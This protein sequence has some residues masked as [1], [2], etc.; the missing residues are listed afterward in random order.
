MSRITGW[1]YTLRSFVRRNAADRDMADEIAF[2]IDCQ[3]RKHAAAGSSI[4]TA[5][6]R[7]LREFG[8]IVRWREEARRA[9]GSGALDV[10]EQDLRATLRGLRRSPAFATMA[11][12]TLALAIG[13]S[14]TVFT[15]INGVLLRPLPFASADRLMTVSYWPAYVKGWLG[16]PAMM[17]RDFVTFQRANR[18]FD[19]VALIIP[20]GAQL[21]RTGEAETL[22]GAWVTPDFFAVLGVKP[23]LGR[24]FSSNDGSTTGSGVVV[25]SNT[26]WRERFGADSSIVGRTIMLDGQLQTVIGV[27]PPGFDF[28]KLPAE[29]PVRGVTPFPPSEY[30]LAIAADPMAMNYPGPVIGRLRPGVTLQQAQVELTTMAKGSFVAFAQ[31]QDWCC[32]L[33][34]RL[35]RSATPQV[36]PLRDLYLAPPSL[37]REESRDARTPLLFFAAAVALVLAIA[38]S[39]VAG[40]ILMRTMSRTHEIAIRA[41]IGATRWRLMRLVLTE[42]LCISVA[43]AAL[44]VP[45]AAAGVRVVLSL[46]PSGA[47]PLANQVSVDSRVLALSVAMVLVCGLFAGLA[48]AIVASHQSPQRTLG[49]GGRM[50]QRHP[51]LETTTAA[52]VAFALMLL[53]GAGL[54]LQSFLR[55]QAVRL[56]FE[57]AGVVVM[58][59]APHGD[60]WWSPV[61]M[62]RLRD[63]VVSG[64]SGLRQVSSVGVESR[65]LVGASPGF[66][67]PLTVE[68]R[69]DTLPG[70][71]VSLVSP[72]Y[73]RT[74]GVPLIAGRTFTAADDEGAPA[75]AIVSHSLAAKAWPGQSALGKR[76]WVDVLDSLPHQLPKPGEWVTV[77]GVVGDAVQGSVRRAAPGMVYFPIDQVTGILAMPIWEFSVRAAGDPAATMRAMRR[78]MHDVAPGVPIEV[79]APLASLVATERAQPLFQTRLVTTFSVLALLL[80]AVGTYSTL[81]YAVVQ[82]RHELAIRL[83]L[84]AQPAN[85][86]RL[87]ASRG[88]GLA[89]A[90]V[91]VGLVGSFALTRALQSMLYHT[92]AT[93]PRVFAAAAVVLLVVAILACIVPTHRATRVD[94]ID[95]LREI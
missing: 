78:V 43:G 63:Q 21:T 9:R 75:V 45:L 56:G 71:V 52:S 89:L 61:A 76:V 15:V 18:S 31:H 24:T 91:C 48:P 55:L 51:V 13:A 17:G 23:A 82:R 12:V 79:L 68:G 39:N 25:I 95:A 67:G 14:T 42:S 59:L 81:A 73:F 36:R 34:H 29:A 2:H 19:K 69:V 49:R 47:I 11:I 65:F 66:V 1:L 37:S 93:D 54:L 32:P 88:A 86:V 40:L 90:G 94:P 8:G 70:V 28:P 64:F 60:Q 58:R 77:V 72:D 4:E 50:S 33:P 7:A 20:H 26:L 22:P 27:M 10:L 3:T 41:A 62:R 46:A 30:W 5:R 87:I 74:L 44:G 38:C 16:A 84:G 35:E 85:V 92:S 80:A 83:A 6:M 53:I 57:P